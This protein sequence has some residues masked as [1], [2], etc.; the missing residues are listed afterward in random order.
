MT[1]LFLDDIRNPPDQSWVV[2]RSYNEFVAYI[3]E[4]GMPEVISFDHDLADAH[5]VHPNS[6][7]SDPIPY[8]SYDEKTGYDC[9]KWLITNNLHG[10]PKRVI[11]HSFN[12]VGA[13]N[14]LQTLAPYCQ[15]QRLPFGS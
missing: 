1:K 12:P 13:E 15:I 8:S 14:I 7:S 2:V 5:Y 3:E 4:H 6:D 11:V 9:A 10:Y